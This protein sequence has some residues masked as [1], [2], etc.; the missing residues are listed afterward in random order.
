MENDADSTGRFLRHLLLH[1][2]N[3]LCAH[4]VRDNGYACA[5]G[6][7]YGLKNPLGA[8][9]LAYSI[10]ADEEIESNQTNSTIL[11]GILKKMVLACNA[12]CENAS[13]SAE[14]KRFCKIGCAKLFDI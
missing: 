3:K 13:L 2:C 12:E 5:K 7:M 10:L 9:V 1:K 4:D 8:G 14:D 11:V 6:C